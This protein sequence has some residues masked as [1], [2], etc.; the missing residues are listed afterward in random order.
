MEGNI[1]NASHLMVL[2]GLVRGAW[3]PARETQKHLLVMCCVSKWNLSLSSR[4]ALRG[5]EEPRQIC[6]KQLMN[7]KL[8]YIT[9]Y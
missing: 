7:S 8:E 4:V 3:K 1:V 5:V 2:I 6:K 9:K